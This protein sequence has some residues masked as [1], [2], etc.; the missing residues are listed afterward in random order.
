MAFDYSNMKDFLEL[1]SYFTVVCVFLV[2]RQLSLARV[3]IFRVRSAVLLILISYCVCSLEICENLKKHLLLAGIKPNY[4]K[5]KKKS[6]TLGSG[7][8]VTH[9]ISC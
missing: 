3:L 2:R 9:G 5:K 1:S 7:L 8:L 4:I 6:Q